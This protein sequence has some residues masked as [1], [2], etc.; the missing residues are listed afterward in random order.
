MR[1]LLNGLLLAAAC[2]ATS[3]GAQQADPASASLAITHVTVV[4]VAGGSSRAD[5]T[6]LVAGNRI[7]AV[8]PAAGVRVPA[9]ARV[10]DGAGKY[11][12]PGLWDMHAH[13]TDRRASLNLYVA[14]GVTAVRDM[15]AIRFATAKAWRDSIAAGWM[16]G[17]RMRIATPIVERPD[18]LAW[19]DS[20]NPG[21]PWLAE[22]FGPTSPEHAVRWL[23][24]V[25]ALG[26]DHVKVRN[27]PRDTTVSRAL[28]NRARELG[29]P[30]YAHANEPFPRSGVSSYE[31]SI[32]PPL[33]ISPAAR[34]SLWRK[35][36][37]AGTGIVPTLVTWPERLQP[38][39]SLIAKID[40]ARNPMYRYA[41]AEQIAEWREE[42]RS[43]VHETP[44]DWTAFYQAAVTN[45]REMHAA[46]VTLMAGSDGGLPTVFPGFGLH[47]ELVQLV[48]LAG[49]TPLEALRAATLAP[50]RFLGLADSLGTVEAGKLADLVLLDADP[51]AD[52][53][54]TRRIHAVILNGRHLDRQAL[55]ALLAEV[56][57]MSGH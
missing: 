53:S 19:V 22:R 11:L 10:V 14:N 57:R 20:I 56:E 46:G 18:W 2:T 27:W 1:K 35:W 33:Q 40:P 5:Q 6:V 41:S 25:A 13:I 38:L 24:S 44:V 43:R 54:N 17:P 21:A 3:A 47:D 29:L 50:A 34:D 32:F 51:L 45:A 36:A 52:V 7:L 23:D 30:V 55:D 4:D 15:G 28:V 16:Q 42:Y 12:I 31:H 37:A 48:T 49:M 8:G 39:D 9:G 26:P